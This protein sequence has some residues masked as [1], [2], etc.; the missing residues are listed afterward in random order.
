MYHLKLPH[1]GTVSIFRTLPSS[2]HPHLQKEKKKKK[3]TTVHISQADWWWDVPGICIQLQF[4]SNW[5]LTEHVRQTALPTLILVVLWHVTLTYNSHYRTRADF[6]TPRLCAVI[7]RAFRQRNGEE[8]LAF[9]FWRVFPC[10][11]LYSHAFITITQFFSGIDCSEWQFNSQAGV[12]I[13]A[14][15]HW[16]PPPRVPKPTVAA[17]V[18]AD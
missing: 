13:P 1:S 8:L 6:P 18:P 12:C 2:I 9:Q 14:S 10:F 15:A 4:L 7:L 16:K 3:I 5:E 11:C 17:G